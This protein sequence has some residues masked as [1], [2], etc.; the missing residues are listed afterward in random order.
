M[1]ISDNKIKQILELTRKHWD[2]PRSRPSVRANFR[3]V[4]LCGTPALGTEVYDSVVSRK[5]VNH[6][7]KSKICPSCGMRSTLLWL[8]EQKCSLP[9]VSFININLTMPDFFWKI[10]KTHREHRH[11]LAALGASVLKRWAWNKYRVRLYV[12]V[13]PHTFGARLNHNTHLHTLV[14]ACG[15]QPDEGRWRE[16]LTFDSAEIMKL[17]RATIT[18]Y[19]RAARRHKQ[20][21]QSPLMKNFEETLNY[22]EKRPWNIFISQPFDSQQHFLE[23]AGR[24]V[25]RLPISQ[26]RILKISKEVVVYSYIDKKSGKTF[27][28]R[29]TPEEFVDRLAI[30]VLD[31]HKHSMRYFGL[32]APRT[33]RITSTR[34]FSILGQQPRP[35]P[36]RE[37]WNVSV[38]RCFGKD[39][40]IDDLGNQ[41]KWVGRLKPVRLPA[42]HRHVDE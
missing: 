27:E 34:I 10:F 9:E 32:S 31:R 17:W 11:D 30:H 40:L 6:T 1:N 37:P 2:H 35:K 38:K 39:P 8:A 5:T 41:M 33:K 4:C 26:K 3:K 36:P 23:Y 22:H 25:R 20:L 15:L 12:I 14:S 42:S 16:S 29:C 21:K 13:I 24:Y 19:F 18:F 28:C 7:C